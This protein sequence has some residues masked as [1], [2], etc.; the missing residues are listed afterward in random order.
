M[1]YGSTV[2]SFLSQK[3]YEDS[4][5]LEKCMRLLTF[6]DYYKHTSPIFKSL[7]VLKLEDII[8]FS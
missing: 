5:S 2:W 8:Q 6:A 1:P 7:K 3:N 4:L